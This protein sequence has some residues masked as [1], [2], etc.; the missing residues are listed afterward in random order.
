MTCQ[1]KTKA[2]LQED[3][4]AS[5]DTTPEVAH[6]Q[7]VPLEDAEEMPV[8]EPRKRRRDG[9]NLA[10]VRHQKTKDRNLDARRRSTQQK[11]TPKG[12]GRS[13]QRDDPSYSCG[14]TKNFVHGDKPERWWSPQW[15]NRRRQEGVPSCNSCTTQE[16]RHQGRT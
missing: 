15:T 9:R 11:R 5:V 1:K 8:G 13:P 2:H 4:P 7:G 3:K 12:F 16:R 6:E 10:A 14:T